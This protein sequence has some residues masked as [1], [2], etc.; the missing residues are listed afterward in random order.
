MFC[1]FAVATGEVKTAIENELCA[2]YDSAS[3]A[4]TG[5]WLSKL[6]LWLRGGAP[7][8][9]YNTRFPY[10]EHLNSRRRENGFAFYEYL[11]IG[12]KDLAA[13]TKQLRRNYEFFGAPVAIFIFV[14]DGPQSMGPYAAL[15]AGCYLQNLLLSAKAHGLGAC[16]QGSL[17]TWSSPVRKQFPDIP[18]GYKLLCGV[19]LG[20]ASDD[21]IK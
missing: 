2:F 21:K 8:G 9:D 13:R 20:Y 12:R 1:V 15:D 17:A 18:P 3:A 7:N 5:G 19:S 11:G 4:Q 16:A 10:P 6:T 14:R